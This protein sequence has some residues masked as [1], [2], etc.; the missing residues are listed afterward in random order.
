[1]IQ[2]TDRVRHR[3]GSLDKQY[4]VMEVWLIKKDYATCRYGESHNFKIETFKL[5]DLRK[6]KNNG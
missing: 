4:G 3:N 6:E 1:M 5:N 2:P